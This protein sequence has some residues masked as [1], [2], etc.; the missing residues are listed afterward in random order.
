M[1]VHGLIRLNLIRKV[2]NSVIIV[3]LIYFG[4]LWK[5]LNGISWS[6]FIS[7]CISYGIMIAIVRKR[8]FQQD[9]KK[10]VFRPY[11]YGTII[12]ICWVVPSY[13]LFLGL[14]AVIPNEITSF[15]ILC[16]VVG[17]AAAFAF[18]KKPMLLGG[19]VAYVQSDFLQMFQKKNKKRK[20]QAADVA[21][22]NV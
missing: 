4:Y 7:T 17:I 15:V 8:I 10:L 9:W 20:K 13:F 1:R 16:C 2:Q 5:G 14:K 21:I 22:E 6:V 18:I 12:T 11:Y 19:D 3:V